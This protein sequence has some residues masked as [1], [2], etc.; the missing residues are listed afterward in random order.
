MATNKIKN[1]LDHILF[2]LHSI[3]PSSSL[4][5]FLLLYKHNNTRIPSTPTR[6][7]RCVRV[8]RGYPTRIFYFPKRGSNTIDLRVASA[9]PLPTQ[10]EH[11]DRGVWVSAGPTAGVSISCD[12]DRFAH[13]E[14][15]SSVRKRRFYHSAR[16]IRR[17]GTISLGRIVETLSEHS[18]KIAGKTL[19][20]QFRN[21][22]V[23]LAV[24]SIYPL[25]EYRGARSHIDR[26][27]KVFIIRLSRR[28]YGY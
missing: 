26:G 5:S 12:T 28:W 11:I 23:F 13:S 10:S 22:E 3:S 9:R 14:L 15:F 17:R 19:R 6:L 24:F 21:T 20:Q 7:Y 1:K 8:H 25:W 16:S 4:S 2:V 18:S 27:A